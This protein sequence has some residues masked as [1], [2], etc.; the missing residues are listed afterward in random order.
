MSDLLLLSCPF[1][2]RQLSRVAHKNIVGLY[3]ACTRRPNVCLVMEFCEH[4]L[5]KILHCRKSVQYSVG[6]AMSWTLQCAE[7]V[8]YLHAMQPKALIH[9]DLKPPNLLL[10]EHGTVLKIC[11]F[12]TVAD[13][14]TMMT[15]NKG[16][17]AWMAPEVFEGSSYTEKCDVFSWGI[18]LWE[19]LSREQPFKEIETTYSIMWHVHKGNR[20]PL[21]EGCPRPIHD[22][23]TQC[24]DRIPQNRP[25]M[26]DV[27]EK[28][29]QLAS[30][31]PGGDVPLRLTDA[32]E[33]D[34][35]DED[36]DDTIE[37]IDESD[38]DSFPSTTVNTNVGAHT[39]EKSPSS[40]N[41]RWGNIEC[42]GN[43]RNGPFPS[44]FKPLSPL[45]IEVEKVRGWRFFC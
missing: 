45:E 38:P 35:D 30:L 13:K 20:P 9:R 44:N 21:I 24:W 3:G 26:E 12:G 4:S 18:I 22:I 25:S 2:V 16:S 42:N 31:F 5:Y 41:V 37:S 28:M 23:M 11:D 8:A 15:N 6:H 19:V 36:Y 43:P 17:A 27:V 29:T 33:E 7:G 14:A 34:I 39:T 10:R 40:K 32:D 1:Q